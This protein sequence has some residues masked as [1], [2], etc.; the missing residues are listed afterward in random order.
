MSCSS[1]LRDRSSWRSN[2]LALALDGLA[3]PLDGLAL[4]L[5]G[6][7][8]PLRASDGFRLHL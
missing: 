7:A 4:A 3:L 8:L 5:D 2:G 1:S 6:L